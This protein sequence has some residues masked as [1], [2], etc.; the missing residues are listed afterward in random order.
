MAKSFITHSCIKHQYPCIRAFA[1]TYILLKKIFSCF[2]VQQLIFMQF[3]IHFPISE[4]G[5]HVVFMWT[6]MWFYGPLEVSKYGWQRLFCV[7]WIGLHFI[8]LCRWRASHSAI[9]CSHEVFP[10]LFN[11]G[12]LSTRTLW[13]L[14]TSQASIAIISQK[15]PSK[16]VFQSHCRQY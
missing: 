3:L 8:I 12:R 1:C 2:V 10:D 11:S 13:G 6:E 4:Q 5:H 16:F 15:I 9:I 14:V 7:L